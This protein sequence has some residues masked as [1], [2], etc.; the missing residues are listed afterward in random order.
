MARFEGTLE[1]LYA[2]GG[3][4]ARCSTSAAARAC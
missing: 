1:E 3:A 2:T 4:D